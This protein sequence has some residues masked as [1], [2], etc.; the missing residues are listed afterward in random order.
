[1]YFCTLQRKKQNKRLFLRGNRHGDTERDAANVEVN[2]AEQE[3]K[4]L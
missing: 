4:L 2:K 3:K 1:M